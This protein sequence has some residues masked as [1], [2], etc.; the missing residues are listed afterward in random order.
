MSEL[1]IDLGNTRL[2]WRL[3]H[4]GLVQDFGAIPIRQLSL[5]QLHSRLP[6]SF[7]T[8]FF[9]SVANEKNTSLLESWAAENQVPYR[10]FSTQAHF[11]GLVNAYQDTLSLGVD[12]WLAMVAA[13]QL[14]QEAVCVVDCGSAITFDYITAEGHHEGGYIIPGARLMV[15]SLTRDTANI[16]LSELEYSQRSD[17]ANHLPGLNTFDAVSSGCNKMALHGVY[18]LIKEAQLNGYD[19]LLCGGDG[20]LIANELGLTYI[21]GLVLDG[22]AEVAGLDKH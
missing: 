13:R 8:L 10:R 15:Q 14:T 4:H 7:D 12:R 1:L 18:A 20:K 3:V 22:V 16:H 9:A 17:Q 2:K 6:A 11:K 19:V 21:E 5:A